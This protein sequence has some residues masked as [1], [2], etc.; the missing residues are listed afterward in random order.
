MTNQDTEP[1]RLLLFFYSFAGS[2]ISS[3]FSPRKPQRCRS[4][5]Y[6]E[7]SEEQGWRAFGNFCAV[8]R[9]MLDSVGVKENRNYFHRSMEAKTRERRPSRNK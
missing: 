1:V 3:V 2:R 4:E 5:E 8:T 9:A 6:F 7:N